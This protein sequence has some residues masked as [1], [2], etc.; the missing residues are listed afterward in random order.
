LSQEENA[1]LHKRYCKALYN[2]WKMLDFKGIMHFDMNHPISIPLAD[3]FVFPDVQRGVPEH[4]TLERDSEYFPFLNHPRQRARRIIRQREPFQE[5]LAKH[6]RL[7]VLGDPGSGKSTLLRYLLLQL[8]Q[9]NDTFATIS[10]LLPEAAT[11]VPLYMPL[12]AYAEVF[13]TNTPGTR[14]L[15]DFLPIYLRDN[16]LSDY[17]D[18]LQG[19]SSKEMCSFSSMG[20]MRSPT[21]HF[22]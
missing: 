2:H 8:V 16:Y 22:A 3:V 9:E 19:T 6:R 20:L 10:P 7:A 13:L 12:A 17:I 18:F 4:E 11:S 1:I 5:A 21:Q 15:E 14:S